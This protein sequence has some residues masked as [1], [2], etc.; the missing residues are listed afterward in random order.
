MKYLPTYNRRFKVK[1]VSASD[2]H[3]AVLSMRE[4][5]KIFCIRDERTLRNDFTIVY[6]G[7]L[8]LIKDAIKTQEVTVEERMDGSLHITQRIRI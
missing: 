7:K 6:Y 8:S 5:D 4:L 1:V 2:V 3:Q